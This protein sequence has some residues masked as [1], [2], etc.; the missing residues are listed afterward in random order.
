MANRRYR[1]M[2]RVFD[3]P[4]LAA[5]AW[6]ATL[7][8]ALRA[9]DPFDFFADDDPPRAESVGSIALIP[10]RGGLAQRGGW[11]SW[12]YDEVR[13]DIDRALADESVR[14][15]MLDVDSPGGEV[16]GNFALTDY[17]AGLRGGDKPVWAR[18]DEQATSA[19]YNIAA[20]AERVY[21]TESASVG[22]IGVVMAH[23]SYE[24]AL[25]KAGIK[26]TYIHAGAHKA[27][28]N[29][30]EDLTPE[31]QAEV[32]RRVDHIYAGF[33]SRVAA[34]RDMS[35]ASVRA[36]E[37]RIYT[38]ADA[39]DLKLVDDILGADEALA[40]FAAHL[41]G[42]APMADQK[43]DTAA[44]AAPAAQETPRAAS[45]A[46]PALMTQAD[47]DRAVTAALAAR[48]A[49]QSAIAALPG[50]AERPALA[51][52]LVGMASISVEQA[53]D[54]LATAPAET[55]AETQ[56]VA[57]EADALGAA[58]E[59]T[60]STNADVNTSLAPTDPGAFDA[61]ALVDE[62]RACTNIP[63]QQA[64]AADPRVIN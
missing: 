20:A 40:A 41:T 5:P 22:S 55:T 39:L 59:A 53:G 34:N 30:A 57:A 48:D 16:A 24:G 32:Q 3:T 33:V 26:V 46:S 21:A 23:E 13:A 31:V 51:A 45:D 63:G 28:G 58:M 17:I 1:V 50:A 62:W 38:A 44:Q 56:A 14:G 2:S 10:V 25:A 6:I 35:E 4:M 52:K 12:G 37:A 11:F 60:G 42:D 36:T 49:R 54:L 7:A 19:A 15:I 64:R 27:D 43:N 8:D 29:P 9:S 47:V 18:V 61:K